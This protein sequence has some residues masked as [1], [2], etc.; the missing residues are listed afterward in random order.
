MPETKLAQSK[1]APMPEGREPQGPGGNRLVRGLSRDTVEL[2][3]SA[4]GRQDIQHSIR[5]LDKSRKRER[6]D[7]DLGPEHFCQAFGGQSIAYNRR[8]QPPRAEESRWLCPAS[9]ELHHRSCAVPVVSEKRHQQYPETLAPQGLHAAGQRGVGIGQVSHVTQD[10]ARPA[11]IQP[12][13]C[14]YERFWRAVVV[15]LLDLREEEAG[16][17]L[18]NPVQEFAPRPPRPHHEQIIVHVRTVFQGAGGLAASPDCRPTFSAISLAAQD[19][20]TGQKQQYHR[21]PIDSKY[22]GTA[23]VH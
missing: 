3:R 11:G 4:E 21:R 7:I 1:A 2:R 13:P 16:M 23:P 6:Q 8:L 19:Y 20:C 15:P 22:P 12:F 17:A 9:A 10:S 18:Q 14:P 5:I